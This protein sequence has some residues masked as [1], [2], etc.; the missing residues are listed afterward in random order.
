MLRRNCKRVDQYTK[1]ALL[2]FQSY[3]GVNLSNRASA[4]TLLYYSAQEQLTPRIDRVL[5]VWGRLIP[6]RWAF[7]FW[8]WLVW[9]QSARDQHS[10][11]P[12][13]SCIAAHFFDLAIATSTR[14]PWAGARWGARCGV[15][16]RARRASRVLNCTALGSFRKSN[17]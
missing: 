10:L 11:L 9:L 3:L 15:G 12:Q 5:W 6:L 16:G 4:F 2:S 14:V 8:L 13:R 17:R 7:L 1:L